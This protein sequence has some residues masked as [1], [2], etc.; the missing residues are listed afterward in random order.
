I[1]GHGK[2]KNIQTEVFWKNAHNVKN[3]KGSPKKDTIEL[4]D[5]SKTYYPTFCNDIAAVRAFLDRKNDLG[6]CNTSSLILVGAETGAT[7]GAIWLNSEWQRY[8]LI[9]P[10]M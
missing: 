5:M 9:P 8:K 3:V 6:V 1:S 7:L 10:A 2:S 4:G